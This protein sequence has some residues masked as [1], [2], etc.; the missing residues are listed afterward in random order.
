M[1]DDQSSIVSNVVSSLHALSPNPP[2]APKEHPRADENL[3]DN[4]L[5]VA[6][7][8]DHGGFEAKEALKSYLTGLGYRVTD[9]GTLDGEKC[10]Y[11]DYAV[12]V[13]RKVASEEVERGIMIDGAGIGSSM[14]CNKIK[15]IRAALCYDMKTIVNS[16]EHNNANVLTLGGPLHSTDEICQMAKTWLV[17][18]FEGGRHWPRINKMMAAERGY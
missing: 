10:D 2:G 16:R 1:A 17:T 18:R 5:R 12:K 6:L 14:V 3:K 8:S 11:P 13:A 4:V 7:G 9:V 15:G